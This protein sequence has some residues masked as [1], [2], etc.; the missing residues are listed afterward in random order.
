M[1]TSSIKEEID[2]VEAVDGVVNSDGDVDGDDGMVVSSIALNGIKVISEIVVFPS[3][4][5]ICN[6]FI[7]YPDSK[8]HTRIISF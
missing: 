7:L 4:T 2:K 5:F 3:T 1:Q 8:N 6:C